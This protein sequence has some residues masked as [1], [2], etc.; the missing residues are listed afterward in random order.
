MSLGGHVEAFAI[1]AALLIERAKYHVNI[2][3]IMMH[4]FSAGGL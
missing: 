3:E 1:L 4:G 2:V